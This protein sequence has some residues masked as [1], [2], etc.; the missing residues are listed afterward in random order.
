MPA[1]TETNWYRRSPDAVLEQLETQREGVSWE[2]AESR[3]EKHGPNTIRSD[4]EISV[5]KVLLDQF[6]SPLIYVLLAALVV[7]LAIQHWADSIVIGA[8]LLIN[9]TIGFFQ[10]YR[11]ETAVQALMKMVSPKARVRRDGE[12]R[13]IEGQK[14]VAGDIVMLAE[15]EV[16]PADIR[17]LECTSLQVNESA[18]TGES[19]P[20]SKT[21][22]PMPESEKELPPADQQNMAFMGTAITAGRA[23]GVI[24]ATGDETEFGKIAEGV[25]EAGEIETPLERRMHRLANWIAA[26]ILVVAAV[27][28]AIGLWMGREIIDM[29]LLAA[30]L[31]VSAIPEGLPVVVTVTLAIGVRRMARRHAVI[32]HLPAVE[33]LGSTTVIVSDKTGTLTQNQMTVQHV[34]AG[35]HQ[36]QLVREDLSLEGRIERDGEPVDV[37]EGSPLH[38]ALLVGLLNNSA[39]LEEPN[40]HTTKDVDNQELQTQGDPMEVALLIAAVKAGL[41]REKLAQRYPQIDEVPFRTENRFS[42]TIHGV[43]DDQEGPLVLIKGAPERLLEMC[44][45]R[46]NDSGDEVELDRDAFHQKNEELAAQGLRVLA[47]AIGRGQQAAE[48]I[49]SDNPDGMTMVGMQGLLDPPRPEAIQAVDDCHRTGIRV[50]MVTG[51]HA[52]TAAAIAHQVHL[53]QPVGHGRDQTENNGSQSSQNLEELPDVCHGQQLGDL[54]DDELDKRVRDFHIFARVK[55]A[56]KMQIVERLKTQQQIVAVTGDG[57]NDAP[58]L[59]SAHLGVAMGQAGTD[60]AKE[61]SDMVITDDNFA[62]VYAAVE[63]GPDSVSQYPYGNLLPAEHRCR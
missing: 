5:W 35:D 33:T 60:V 19:V 45:R 38:E 12:E 43:P 63:E 14:L 61:A 23:E 53:D 10:E 55:P 20:V 26:V 36:Y 59:K 48:S 62:S 42:A 37:T 17:L 39:K 29:F 41:S 2:E 47:M 32:R 51:D 13:K 4:Q 34:V 21:A 58:A 24:T 56:H 18:L 16:V 25:R 52:Q 54:S 3:L 27:A 7:N 28:F 9:A 11:A 1:E 44:Q 50:I 6:A 15:G 31:A 30:A 22:E 49:K 8:V 46:Q 40:T 57:V